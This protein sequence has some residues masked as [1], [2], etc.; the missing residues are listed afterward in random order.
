MEI[1]EIDIKIITKGEA[2]EMSEAE[3]RRWY[4]EKIKSL[5]NPAFGTPEITVNV[6]RKEEA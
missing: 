3:V 5:F 6:S 1:H 2:C 4:E